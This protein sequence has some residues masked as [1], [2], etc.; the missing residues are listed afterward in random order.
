M[1]GHRV[2]GLPDLSEQSRRRGGGHEI[3]FSPGLPAGYEPFGGADVRSQVDV[4]DAVPVAFAADS[5]SSGD[6]GIGEVEIDV[7]EFAVG[8]GQQIVD[9]CCR[10]DVPGP[11]RLA[12]LCRGVRDRLG[13]VG[14]QH[15]GPALVQGCGQRR[16]DPRCGPGD[17]GSTSLDVHSP[18]P[19]RRT[20][21]CPKRGRPIVE[22]VLRFKYFSI[23]VLLSSPAAGPS[24]S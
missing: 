24:T 21:L 19:L 23:H 20:P 9:A 13:E 6:P 1:F 5:G 11:V 12:Q 15:P 14:Q 17:D 16:P 7:A 4:E 2:A 18:L 8:C 3:S 22:P 10:G